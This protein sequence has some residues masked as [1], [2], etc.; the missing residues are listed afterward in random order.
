MAGFFSS[1]TCFEKND[2]KNVIIVS[3]LEK[4][5][6]KSS[7]YRSDNKTRKPIVF[8]TSS[9][10]SE[11]VERG[12][13]G[14]QNHRRITV[15]PNTAQAMFPARRGSR[16]IA[17]RIT[18][19][20]PNEDNFDSNDSLSEFS[21]SKSS[22]DSSQSDN[23]HP[24][25][26]R[27][28]VDS[29]LLSVALKPISGERKTGKLPHTFATTRKLLIK[30]DDTEK[31]IEKLS[32]SRCVATTTAVSP[33]L[34]SGNRKHPRITSCKSL[35]KSDESLGKKNKRFQRT[36]CCENELKSVSTAKQDSREKSEELLEKLN[37][38]VPFYRFY[39]LKN[40]NEQ[41]VLRASKFY[42]S[43]C[44]LDYIFNKLKK[45][46]GNLNYWKKKYP[47]AFPDGF[48]GCFPNFID[49]ELFVESL[50]SDTYDIEWIKSEI[51]N[52]LVV[53]CAFG[54]HPRF[55]SMC[56]EEF[57]RTIELFCEDFGTYKVKAIGE[58]GL[59][60]YRSTESFADQV[61]ALQR[62]IL[63]AVRFNLP[64]V[65]HCRSGSVDAE[66]PCLRVLASEK[67]LSRF[68]NIHRHCFTGSWETAQ[69]WMSYF[70]NIYFGYTS[71]CCNF[72]AKS[73]EMEALRKIPLERILLETDAPYFKPQSFSNVQTGS[74]ALPGMAISV[75]E[76]LA[77]E[78]G[79][80][81]DA[82]IQQTTRNF[83]RMYVFKIEEQ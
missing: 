11:S 24:I 64:L 22:L 10:P 1:R 33:V 42:D 3:K 37:L 46:S 83:A 26:K 50:K 21:V 48:G 28:L 56:T 61:K 59:D 62:Q 74:V 6:T 5:F 51:Q 30:N 79:L 8:D 14:F 32:S 77:M 80:S 72:G 36:G 55:A 15:I 12:S 52:P 65:I 7:I 66:E 9:T 4:L 58:C 34:G 71:G 44:H 75:A 49:P 23:E 13:K 82:V 43:H 45:V 39:Q 17:K 60:F 2:S 73:E 25:R 76:F 78:R 40:D 67:S 27:A 47:E 18:L 54:C 53:G 35:Q 16:A 68:H 38:C 57:I 31:N 20:R 70:P 41:M 81:V 69:K 63:V 19:A 29:R